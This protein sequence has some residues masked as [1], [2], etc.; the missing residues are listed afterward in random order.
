MK[1][2]LS[3]ISILLLISWRVWAATITS[4]GSGNWSNPATWVGGVVPG[5]A[6]DVVIANG[7]TVTVDGNFA[8]D[9]IGMPAGANNTN[10]NI[11]GTNTLTVT[12]DVSSALSLNKKEKIWGMVL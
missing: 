4:A 2:Q 12:N 11:A 7:H 5:L 3:I 10:L 6:D 8:C 1:R 9:S